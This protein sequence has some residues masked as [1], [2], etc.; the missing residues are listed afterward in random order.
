MQNADML[1]ILS[2]LDTHITHFQGSH[3][4]KSESIHET[5]V[6]LLVVGLFYL[7]RKNMGIKT[8][9]GCAPELLVNDQIFQ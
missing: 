2:S 1:Q 6:S 7:Q 5:H 9:F 8:G 4:W 3:A